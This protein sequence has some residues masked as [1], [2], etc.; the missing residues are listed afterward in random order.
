MGFT[1]NEQMGYLFVFPGNTNGAKYLHNVTSH[2]YTTRNVSGENMT[3][4]EKSN[5]VSK[6]IIHAFGLSRG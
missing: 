4:P 6:T 1:K 5:N 2:V 3:N